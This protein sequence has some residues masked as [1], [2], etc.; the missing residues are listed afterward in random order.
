MLGTIWQWDG[1]RTMDQ[2]YGVVQKPL[3]C[4]HILY[5][6]HKCRYPN[7]HPHQYQHPQT[8]TVTNGHMVHAQGYK[9]RQ[10]GHL[11]SNLQSGP[12]PP[13]IIRLVHIGNRWVGKLDQILRMLCVGCPPKQVSYQHNQNWNRNQFRHY[14]VCFG[15]FDV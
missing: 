3:T 13:T 7:P 6:L 8:P 5:N 10:S 2:T 14:S 9:P 11:P 15:C 4:R 12:R 1:N